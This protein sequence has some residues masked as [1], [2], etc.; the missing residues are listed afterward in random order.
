[1]KNTAYKPELMHNALYKMLLNIPVLSPVTYVSLLMFGLASK[2]NS[3]SVAGAA[4][5][6]TQAT[7]G[8]QSPVSHLNTP[9][10]VLHFVLAQIRPEHQSL[11]T[12]NTL[13]LPFFNSNPPSA[14]W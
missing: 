13:L 14:G 9:L 7:P 3:A 1:M 6:P 4:P 5:V 2:V 11:G 8:P 10:E 12:L